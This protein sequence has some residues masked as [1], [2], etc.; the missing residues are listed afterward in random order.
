MFRRLLAAG[1]GLC[2]GAAAGFLLT[3]GDPVVLVIAVLYVVVALYVSFAIVPREARFTVLSVVGFAIALRIA[4]AVGLYDGL[5]AAGRGGF[6][7]GD[8]AAYADLSSR[9]ARLLHGEAAPFDYPAESYLLG[10]YVYLETAVFYLFGPKVLVVELMNAMMGGLLVTFVFEIA[11]RLFIDVRAGVVA[12]ALVTVYPSL[13]LW[14]AL[15]LKDSLSLLII[16]I[17]LWL[18]VIYQTRHHWWLVPASFVPLL[19]L[20]SLRDYIFVGLALVIPASVI[21]APGDPRAR[22]RIAPDVVALVL[23]AVLLVSS[24]SI[25][26]ASTVPSLSDLEQERAG[27]GAGANTNFASQCS[28]D[29]TGSSVLRTIR[30]LPCAAGFVLFAPFPWSVRRILDLLPIPEMIVWYIALVGGVLVLAR[31]RR[32]W[33]SLVPLVLYVGGTL[34]V[35]MLTE[36]NV[37]TLYRHRA[38]VIPF[39][40][41]VASPAFALLLARR[42]PRTL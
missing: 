2:G 17:V 33:Q 31:Y 25:A 3:D 19:P 16:G 20:A 18:I 12:A 35:F 23:S 32:S 27:M 9:L 36:G 21:L 15:N 22:E 40:L 42:A 34:L 1:T 5:L 10:T 38:M 28:G 11:R 39:V 37:G 14:S 41:I 7:T 30:D 26:S 8:D 29:A 6:V 13:V 24:F 4:A